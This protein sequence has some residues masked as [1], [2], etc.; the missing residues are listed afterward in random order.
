MLV[1]PKVARRPFDVLKFR[2]GVPMRVLCVSPL[3][4]LNTHFLGAT[5]I[6]GGDA[7]PACLTGIPAKYAGYVVVMYDHQRRLMRLTQQSA[8]L[9]DEQGMFVAG[10]ILE[11]EKQRERRPVRLVDCGDVK[12]FDRHAIVSRVELLSVIARLHGLPGL[13][14]GWSIA[15]GMDAVSRSAVTCVRLALAGL[16]A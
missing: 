15:M 3:V 10:R 1:E 12:T 8:F 9:G 11:V 16:P 5:K 14:P 13:E 2:V 6:C 4:G 7:C